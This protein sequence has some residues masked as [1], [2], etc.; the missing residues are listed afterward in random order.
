MLTILD[1]GAGNVTS[2]ALAFA[3]LGVPA[4]VAR[5]AADADGADRIVFPGVGSAAACMAELRARGFDR[6]LAEARD[7]GTP[8]LAVC[9]GMQLLF[10]FSDEDGGVSALGFWPGSVRRFAFPAIA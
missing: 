7:H 1:Y 10:G 8:T 5:T 2:M 4:R 3:H 9:I 6:T